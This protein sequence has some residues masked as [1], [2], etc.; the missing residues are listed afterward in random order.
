MHTEN[1]I[2][3]GVI[4]GPS[5]PKSL[6]SFFIP[7]IEECKALARGVQTFDASIRQCFQL[8]AYLIAAFGDMPAIS[9]L[10]C[11]KGHNG[12]CPCRCC[13]LRG[14][15]NRAKSGLTYYSPLCG[16]KRPDEVTDDGWNPHDLP[17]RTH[18]GHQA[19]LDEIN[20][21]ATVQIRQQLATHYGINGNSL[22]LSLP[23][24][25]FPDSF[26]YDIMHLFFP[27]ICPMLRDHWT[28]TGKYKD[29]APVDPGYHLAS[30]IWEQIGRETAEAYK[31]I[32][33][34]FVGALPDITKTKY[35][36]EF[37][38]FWFVH[39]GP[40]LLRNRFPNNK[41]YQHYLLLVKIIKT[42][43][44]FTVTYDKLEELHEDVIKWVE[45]Y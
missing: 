42:C 11:L 44:Q 24:I 35:K 19:H 29:C 33:S 4:P 14:E 38:S 37:W 1:I 40:I 18:E 8:H 45:Q 13:L 23:L 10:L 36:A 43:L 20:Q 17:L 9:K 22:L 26:P 5:S 41:Y 3:L 15:R 2:P 30:D 28:G 25:S 21:G 39:L 7:F 32:P 6:D 31:T 34:Q 16:P 12:Y 27:N